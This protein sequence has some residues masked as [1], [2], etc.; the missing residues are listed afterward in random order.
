M[1]LPFKLCLKNNN[2]H[3]KSDNEHWYDQVPKSVEASSEG[4]VPILGNKQL[5]TDRTILNNKPDTIIRDNEEGTRILTDVAVSGDRNVTNKENRIIL[6]H[7]DLTTEIRL[8][9]N[10]EVKVIPV[11]TG[12]TGTISE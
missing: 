12:A 3:V 1:Y 4:K 9:W 10:M 11:I 6:K 2:N 8:V 7:K 5:Q